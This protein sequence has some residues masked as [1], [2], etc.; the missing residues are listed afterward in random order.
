MKK[1]VYPAGA[2]LIFTAFIILSFANMPA[3]AQMSTFTDQRDGKKYRTVQIGE[4]TWMAENLNFKTNVSW[5]YD[6]NDN[7]C[8]KY[9]RL[10][11]RKTALGVCPAGWRLP[12][13]EECRGL[14]QTAGGRDIA[15]RAL[16]SKAAWNSGSSTDEFGFSAMPGGT[17]TCDEEGCEFE[18]IGEYGSWRSATQSDNHEDAFWFWSMSGHNIGSTFDGSHEGSE[19]RSVRCI[20]DAAETGIRELKAPVEPAIR[21]EPQLAQPPLPQPVQPPPVRL[22]Q[23]TLQPPQPQPAQNR[24]ATVKKG[25]SITIFAP[26]AVGLAEPL[27]YIPALVQGEFV[28]N[29]SSYSG[30]E[31]L[32]WERL[33][34]IYLKLFSEKY[35]D[36]AEAKLDLGNLTPTTHFLSGKITKTGTAYNFQISVVKTDDK[37]TVAMFSD[38]FSFGDLSNLTAVRRASLKLLQDMGVTLTARARQELAGAAEENHVNAQNAFARGRDAQ[39]QGTEIAALSYYFQAAA[40]D[41]SLREAVNRSSILNANITSG[42]IGDNVRND[43]A[44]RKQWVE[45]LEE[46]ERF[47]DNFNKI[48]TMPYTLFYTNNIKQGA[49]NYQNETVAMSIETY[50]YGSSIWTISM[51]RALQAVYDGL[52]ATGRKDVWQL[53]SWPQRG[54]TQRNAFAGQRNSF[55]VVFELLNNQNKVIGRQTLQSGGSWGLNWSGR[56]S[57]NISGGDRKTLNFQNVSANEITDRMTIR[58]ASVN[59]EDAEIA[60]VN[61]VLQIRAI[62]ADEVAAN[63]RFRFVKGEVQGFANRNNKEAELIIPSTIWGDPVVSIGDRAFKGARLTNRIIIPNSVKSIGQEVFWGNKQIYQIIIG[64]NV[65]MAGNPFRYEDRYQDNDGRM[66][67]IINDNNGFQDYY[68]KTG[69]K[70]G[71]YVNN[72]FRW[73]YGS[74]HEESIKQQQKTFDAELKKT[75]IYTRRFR[76]GIKGIYGANRDYGSSW[77]G[78]NYGVGGLMNIM[79]WQQMKSTRNPM[80]D[81]VQVLAGMYFLG[82]HTGADL[83]RRNYSVNTYDDVQYVNV[84]DMVISIPVFLQTGIRIVTI[85]AGLR[86]D[87][88]FSS[89]SEYSVSSPIFGVGFGV[90]LQISHLVIDFRRSN[91]I[92]VRFGEKNK[93]IQQTNWGVGWIF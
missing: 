8:E 45:R 31:V 28:S 91:D 40:F 89:D 65:A 83:L 72:N 57:I 59:G 14:V 78:D 63:D 85:E 15:V 80:G 30:I 77:I 25:T 21:E 90:S 20:Q 93:R 82:I 17:V 69:K 2:K 87:I 1:H 9:G 7:N 70:A 38:N 76:A 16:K 84:N 44:W 23:P 50:L 81:T 4:Q 32:D 29:F 46:T 53:G 41:P 66:R 68:N 22:P 33:D 88:P 35:D 52:N 58:V 34:D 36:N 49:V 48:E 64:A 73:T 67:T 12:T 71:V 18:G 75:D 3:T 54:V 47:F 39:R 86:V 19:G 37:R 10:Y 42:N 24:A 60:A 51:E 92:G 79:L 74:T 61:G 13:R 5:C 43:I 27:S 6:D 62:T 55:S 56:P 26:E 11:E